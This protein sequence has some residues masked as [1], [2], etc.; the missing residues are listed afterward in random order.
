MKIL[1]LVKTTFNSPRVS[2][3]LYVKDFI[4]GL[5]NTTS[6]PTF[7][8]KANTARSIGVK[9]NETELKFGYFVLPTTS[10]SFVNNSQKGTYSPSA[11]LAAIKDLTI[12]SNGLVSHSVINLANGQHMSFALSYDQI[13]REQTTSQSNREYGGIARYYPQTSFYLDV[14]YKKNSGDDKNHVGNTTK[15]GAGYAITPRLGIEITTEKFS[16]SDSSLKTSGTATA[17]VMG[18]RF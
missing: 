16:A 2:G 5:K 17:F 18:Y 4:F 10:I 6:N 12:T 8:T 9:V 11:G 3:T 14:G 13:K 7:P 15:F 1:I